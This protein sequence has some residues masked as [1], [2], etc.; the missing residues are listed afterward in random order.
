M[1]FALRV[2]GDSMQEAGIYNG[3][4]VIVKKQD[5]ADDGDIV[6]ALLGDEA[7][8]KTLRNSK[9]KAYLEA[10][11]SKYKAIIDKPFQIIGKVI[12]LRREYLNG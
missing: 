7:T 12:E 2:R 5:T 4:I 9:I 10:A 11:N 3:D 6:I 8:V 1:H